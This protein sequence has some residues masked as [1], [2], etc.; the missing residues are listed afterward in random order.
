M[1]STRP[2]HRPDLLQKGRPGVVDEMGCGAEVPAAVA[3]AAEIAW[4]LNT[5]RKV[6]WAGNGG[7]AS[8]AEHFSAELVGRF[9]YHRSPLRSLTLTGPSALITALA[10]D[11]G[12][13]EVFA[14]QLQA[15]GDEGDVFVGI[16]TSGTS[17]NI[18]RAFETARQLGLVTIAIIGDSSPDVLHGLSD[19]D[20]VI[21]ASGDWV[22]CIQEAHERAGHTIC[23]LVERV[24]FP[25]GDG[26]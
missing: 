15:L 6:L 2:P 9:R 12:Y 24:L 18:V 8:Q 17:P 10:N 14:R 1:G 7:S 16:S 13:A 3:A 22:A 11:Y 5:G 19:P 26:A 21:C 20:I 25:P 4:A 23:E